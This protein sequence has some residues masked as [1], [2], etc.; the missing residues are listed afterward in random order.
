MRPTLARVWAGLLLTALPVLLFLG[1]RTDYLGH[2]LAGF[3]GTLLL[4]GLPP[5]FGRKPSDRK[6]VWIVLVAILIG[7]FIECTI[8]NIAKFDPIDFGN[9][10]LGAC[11]AGLI[12][13]RTEWTPDLGLW[14]S[15]SSICFMAAGFFVAHP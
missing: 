12:L 13:L 14:I 10:S 11:I 15:F 6:T 3:G 8:C 9:Q 7:F 1:Y 5:L 4:L 2:Y